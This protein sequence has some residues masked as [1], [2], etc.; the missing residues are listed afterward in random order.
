MGGTDNWQPDL[1]CEACDAPAV[2]KTATGLKWQPVAYAICYVVT[3]ADGKVADITTACEYNGPADGKVSVQAVNEY[4]GLSA[5]GFV[6]QGTAVSSLHAAASTVNS[7]YS[8]GGVRTSN[9]HKGLNIVTYTDG[10]VRKV[11]K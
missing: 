1:M 9:L 7:I 2:E 6:G 5:R 4:G 8:V 10:S 11:I 3:D